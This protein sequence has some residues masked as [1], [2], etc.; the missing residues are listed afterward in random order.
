MRHFL[1]GLSFIFSTTLLAESHD[2]AVVD[3]QRVISESDSGKKARETIDSQISKGEENLKKKK[4]EL[5]KLKREFETQ[6]SALS[7]SALDERSSGI[8]KREKELQRMV[9]DLR[10]EL[11]KK[12]REEISRIVKGVQL[13]VAD[14]A[15]TKNASVVLDKGA[16]SGILWA[17]SSIDI[18]DAVINSYNKKK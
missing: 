15:K 10:E 8:E 1:I 3:M 16:G 11:G 12:N 17:S 6:R 13:V 7:A 9:Q 5:D 14:V 2:I 4:E 18:T